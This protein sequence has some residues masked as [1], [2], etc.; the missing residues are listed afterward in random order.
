MSATDSSQQ[1]PAAN[2]LC[3]RLLTQGCTV[4]ALST[5]HAFVAGFVKAVSIPLVTQSS[6]QITHHI[7]FGGS[8][9]SWQF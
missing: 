9:Y 5:I 7:F 8:V 4:I 3:F 6:V 2:L 1:P